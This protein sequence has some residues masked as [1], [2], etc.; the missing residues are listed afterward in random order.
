MLLHIAVSPRGEQSF[1]RRAADE[2][3][4]RWRADHPDGAVCQRDLAEQPLAHPDAAFVRA[5][6]T[7]AELRDEAQGRVL[8]PSDALVDELATADAVLISTPM[9]NFSIP[10]VFKAWVDHVVRPGCT[11]RSTPTGKQGLLRDRP[12]RVLMACGGS[13]GSDVGGQQDWATPYLRYVFKVMGIE[14]VEVL[15]LENCNRGPQAAER[16]LQACVDRIDFGRRLDVAEG[17]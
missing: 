2:V 5:S 15:T 6:L 10:S 16:S 9:H 4:R 7:S 3:V 1:S 13:L 12:V 14:D 17:K 11:F 8:A